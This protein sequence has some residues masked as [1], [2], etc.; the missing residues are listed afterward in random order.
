MIPGCSVSS[1]IS[2]Q[3]LLDDIVQR[4][5]KE[6]KRNP[7]LWEDIGYKGFLEHSESYG[8]KRLVFDKKTDKLFALW[9]RSKYVVLELGA[10]QTVLSELK[11]MKAISHPFIVQERGLTMLSYH[12]LSI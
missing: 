10:E 7:P 6:L 5:T 9:S 12:V 1:L 8:M 11:V 4:R 3:D 2:A